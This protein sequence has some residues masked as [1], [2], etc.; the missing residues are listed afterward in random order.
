MLVVGVDSNNN[1]MIVCDSEIE[2]TEVSGVYDFA[3]PCPKLCDPESPLF[4]GGKITNTDYTTTAP[5]EVQHSTE[6]ECK[7]KEYAI[8]INTAMARVTN[9]QCKQAE[10]LVSVFFNIESLR[11]LL[12]SYINNYKDRNIDAVRV[13]FGLDD[14]RLKIFIIGAEKTDD[15]YDKYK[16]VYTNR[17]TDIIYCSTTAPCTKNGNESSCASGDCSLFIDCDSL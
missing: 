2:T 9:W 16:D 15:I 12:I 10:Q 6:N 13:Y 11:E 5:K 8:D 14:V 1:D 7:I 17:F 4:H 3:L